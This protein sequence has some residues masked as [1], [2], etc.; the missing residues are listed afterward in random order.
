MLCRFATWRLPDPQDLETCDAVR[1]VWQHAEVVQSQYVH[2]WTKPSADRGSAA[3]S[4]T[5]FRLGCSLGTHASLHCLR[6][7]EAVKLPFWIF[8]PV[9]VWCIQT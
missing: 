2:A 8:T 1:N 6:C 5:S 9:A 3:Y 7:L 4:M